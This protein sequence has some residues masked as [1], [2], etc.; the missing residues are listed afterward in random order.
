MST[1]PDACVVDA[2]VGI[3][4]I[5]EETHTEIVQ[6]YFERLN[7]SPPVIVYVPDL[8]FIECANILWK[9][10]RR[11]DISLADSL[12]GLNWLNTLSL[13]TASTARLNEHAVEIGCANSITAY[14][15]TYVALAELLGV[16][17]LTADNRLAAALTRSPYQ[18]ITLDS[19]A[20]S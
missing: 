10:V 1:F 11:G 17:L 12:V 2:S 14:D 13:P 8:F 15:A 18:V 16:P 3:K 20:S 19:I 9:N 7:D 5:L 6:Q 4:L